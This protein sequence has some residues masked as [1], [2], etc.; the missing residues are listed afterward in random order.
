[1]FSD[2]QTWESCVLQKCPIEGHGPLA[3][4]LF[5]KLTGRVSFLGLLS[6]S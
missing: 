4:V 3:Q 5:S 2:T 1:M 6:L